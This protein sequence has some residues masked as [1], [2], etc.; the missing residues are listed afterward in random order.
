M[1]K[2]LDN[3]KFKQV[4]IKKITPSTPMFLSSIE[5]VATVVAEKK[6]LTEKKKNLEV[7]KQWK[8]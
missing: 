1:K 3:I 7:D 5:T 8:D 2:V 6:P 4:L